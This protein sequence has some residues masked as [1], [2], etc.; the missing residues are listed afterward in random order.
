[1]TDRQ[2]T[3]VATAVAALILVPLFLFPWRVAPG[4][5]AASAE[6]RWSPIYQPPLSYVRSYDDTYSQRGS[7][8]LETNSATRAWGVL[9]LQLLAIGAVGWVLYVIVGVDPG[10]D[11]HE[12]PADLPRSGSGRGAL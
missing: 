12:P 7:T 1:V 10:T 9:A 2:N 11:D 4:P 8:R 6:L 5:G 3:V